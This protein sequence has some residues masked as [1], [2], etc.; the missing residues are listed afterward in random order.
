MESSENPYAAPQVEV[1]ASGEWLRSNAEGLSKTAI[2]LSLMYYGIIL[3]LLWT[4]LTIPMMFL[5]AAIRFPLGAGMIIASIMMFVGPVLC[6]SVPPETGAKGLA[7]LS[8]VFQL[9]RV[10]VEFLPFVGIAPNIVPGLA[11]AAGILS[12]VLFV[13]FLRKLAQFIHRD[14]L[15]KRANNVLMMAVIAIALALGSVVGI[16]PLPGLILIG[17]GILALV[18]FV[19]YANLIN[20]LRKAIKTE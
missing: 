20:A 18:L 3:L 4:I 17:V 19:M 5:G 10:I 7:A 8:V 16:G 15:T 12:S 9:I 6:L 11:Q 1:A 14:D 2:G 13:V